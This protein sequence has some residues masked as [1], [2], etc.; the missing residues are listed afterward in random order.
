MYIGVDLGTSS[1]KCVLADGAGKILAAATEAYPLITKND[2][3]SEQNPSD[4][5]NAV[6][7]CIKR[8]PEEML[9]KVKGVSFS[10]Q[11]HGLCCIDK[12]GEVI[13]P[14]IL[15]ND[16]RTFEETD[17][18]NNVIGEKN[19]IA[20]TGNRAVTGFT[21][22]K[23]L[24]VKK[25]EPENFA[26]I[27]K[28]LLPK[29]YVAYKLSGVYATD[30]SDAS[31]TLYFDVKNRKWSQYM[32]DIL[33]ISEDQLPAVYESYEAVGTILPELA[34]EL[35]LNESAKI[36]I[37]GGD[38]AV[39]A[40]GTGT[41]KD[42]TASIS[43]GTSG[44]LFVAG[45]EF[46]DDGKGSLHSFCHADGK[47]HT[48]GVTL[49]AAGSL[50]WWTDDLGVSDVGALIEETKDKPIDDLL[51]LPY[52]SGERSPINAPK[53]KGTFFGLTLASDR[54]SMT[55]SVLEG[56]GF[57]LK[58][59]LSVLRGA[60]L[61]VNSARVIGGGAKSPIWLQMLADITGLRLSTIST[62]DGGALGAVILAMVGCGDEKDVA[63]ACGK[64]IREVETFLPD[65]TRFAE[66]ENKF[67]KFKRLTDIVCDYY[68]G[69]A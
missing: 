39:G 54:A 6:K 61:K 23:V 19:L 65:E 68:G 62:A 44:V 49:S 21:A 67:V 52:L 31:G 24:W 9:A 30:V 2:G 16:Q 29:D 60:G 45:D 38:Q 40:I 7:K 10:G 43:L 63:T 8:L 34:E 20:A 1:V 64:I 37:G 11:M 3:W 57:T 32:L 42:G 28:I 51:F 50:K 22:P 17:Y 33:G 12:S 46:F 66:Y 36:I 27:H 14:A 5:F 56:V 13:R 48:M 15:W 41:V 55:K 59:C 58:N 47:Y 4:W 25:N 69:K 18:L 26:K 53:V 35:K